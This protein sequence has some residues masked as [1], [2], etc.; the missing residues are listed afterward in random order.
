VKKGSMSIEAVL[1]KGGHVRPAQSVRHLEKFDKKN[2]T[3]GE[4]VNLWGVAIQTR[5]F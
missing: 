4:C 5:N 2:S 1:F 3:R